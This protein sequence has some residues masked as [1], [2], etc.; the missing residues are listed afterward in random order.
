MR[1]DHFHIL[2]LL[3]LTFVIASCGLIQINESGYRSINYTK[4]LHIKAFEATE[5]YDNFNQG[6]NK[7]LFKINSENILATAKDNE[8]TWLHIWLPFCPNDNCQ[9]IRPYKTLANKYESKGLK[10]LFT[11]ATYDFKYIFKISGN[12]NFNHPIYVLDGEYYGYKNK[13][14]RQKLYQELNKEAKEDDYIFHD[15]Y[16]FKGDSLVFMGKVNDS[17]MDKI[18]N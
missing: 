10:T 18:I 7:F 9:N 3:S 16:I 4:N 5:K 6:D 14:I 8:Y 1:T 12:A 11:S 13:K 17:I 15:D 2:L